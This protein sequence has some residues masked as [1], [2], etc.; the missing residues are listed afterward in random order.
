M[1]PADLTPRQTE[2]VLAIAAHLT[3]HRRPPTY[4][5]LGAAMGTGGT[6][7]V[8]ST[9]DAL[10][11]KGWLCRTP[12]E[13]RSIVLAGCRVRPVGRPALEFLDTPEGWAL[14]DLLVGPIAL[15][16]E[17]KQCPSA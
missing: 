15:A 3:K 2:W 13:S 11:A 10:E 17:R 1:Q 7:A 9:L 6:N 12:Y 4:V 5:E 8:K 16:K 14:A